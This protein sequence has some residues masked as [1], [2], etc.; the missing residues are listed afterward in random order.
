M[1]IP[2]SMPPYFQWIVDKRLAICAH[3]FHASHI[4]YILEQRIQTVISVIYLLLKT[5]FRNF[6]TFIPS[7]AHDISIKNHSYIGLDSINLLKDLFDIKGFSGLNSQ[8]HTGHR[9]GSVG[10]NV[11]L[12]FM[13]FCIHN[14]S[15]VCP[16]LRIIGSLKRER[17]IGQSKSVASSEPDIFQR[18]Y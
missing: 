9:V 14:R 10:F 1:N 18:K 7:F 15:I 13:N 8:L 6:K 3:P 16:Q 17:Q 2:P 11:R 4:R 5:S 12:R